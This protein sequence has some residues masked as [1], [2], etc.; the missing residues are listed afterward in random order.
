[1]KTLTELYK[2]HAGKV[3]D[4]WSFYLDEYDRIL[5]PYRDKAVRL[6]ELGIQNGGSLELWD[7]FFRNAEKL[8]GCDVN[9]S[10]AD[11]KYD[12]ARIAVVVADSNTAEAQQEIL[13]HCP[14]F[15]IIIDDGSHRPGDIIRFFCR[16]FQ[17]LDEGGLYLVE[18]LHCSYWKEF[19]GGLFHPHSSIN[20]F[21]RLADV[22]NHEHWAVKRTRLELLDGFARRYGVTFGEEL[23]ASIHSIKFLN[24]LC[25]IDKQEPL[26]NTLG[27]RVVAGT[28]ESVTPGCREHNGEIGSAP[29]QHYNEW[30]VR[31]FPIDEELMR[32]EAAEL[33]R[34][35]AARDQH[36]AELNTARSRT[37]ARL[38]ETEAALAQTEAARAQA[39]GRLTEVDA[40]RV[41]AEG[42][43]AESQTD[44]AALEQRIARQSLIAE[45]LQREKAVLEQT[46]ADLREEHRQALN[47]TDR[48]TGRLRDIEQSTT[49]QATAVLRAAA[50]GLPRPVRR[51]L[52]RAA[53]AAYWVLTPHRLPA[54]I[55]FLRERHQAS[56]ARSAATALP[57]API[58]QNSYSDL[59]PGAPPLESWMT[60]IGLSWPV[61]RPKLQ[62]FPADWL[63]R[64]PVATEDA[65]F[66]YSIDEFIAF[67][68][69]LFL[70]G[71]ADHKQ[72]QIIAVFVVFHGAVQRLSMGANDGQPLRFDLRLTV[73]ANQP[74]S[75][76]RVGFEFTDGSRFLIEAPYRQS[77][78]E[79]PSHQVFQNFQAMV[80]QIDRGQILE[81]GSRARSGTLYREFIPAGMSYVGLDILDGPNVDVVGDAHEL[82]RHFA[83]ETFDAA[84]SI[85]VFEHLLMPWKAAIELNKVLKP[86]GVAFIASHQTFNLH[87]VPWDFWRFSDKAWHAL[88]NKFTGFEILEAQMGERAYIVGGFLN[89]MT[90]L[91]DRAPAFMAS[92]VICRKIGPCAEQWHADLASLVDSVYPQ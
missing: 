46:L 51:N 70:S 7:Q 4:K 17:Y 13:L 72:K 74:D 47:A 52:R 91:M 22:I 58:E 26:K 32:A 45:Q 38:T 87:E 31:D 50:G 78:A 84:Y 67:R 80:R 24:S 77:W 14:R 69:I 71:S 62:I 89:P 82:S 53:R 30:S 40:A 76:I 54:R 15:D 75:Q 8:V 23:L 60:S 39:E 5:T 48:S 20:F 59:S 27:P 1:M 16:Y 88:F 33:G 37:E 29:D 79:A 12:S 36:I 34:I 41:R 81:I 9:P 64:G 92:T 86:G 66:S 49:W 11:L 65:D 83:P 3:S 55:R 21:K 85:A 19:A 44:K 25:I 43:V 57:G 90:W 73:P 56:H 2:S 68:D 61:R 10:C 35:I 18:D 28:S 63:A 6:L 42:A